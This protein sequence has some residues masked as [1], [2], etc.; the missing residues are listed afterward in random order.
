[1]EISKSRMIV[2]MKLKQMN[3]QD[4]ERKIKKL[5]KSTILKV[6]PKRNYPNPKF[7]QVLK[8]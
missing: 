3:F 5:Q 1:M 2:S 4:L 6:H 8:N 7:D